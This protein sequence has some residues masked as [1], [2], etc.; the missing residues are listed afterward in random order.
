M[1]MRASSTGMN[2]LVNREHRHPWLSHFTPSCL[3]G[4]GSYGESRPSAMQVKRVIAK[5]T[6][7]EMVTGLQG[8]DEMA[9]GDGTRNLLS[10]SEAPSL[11]TWR[12]D[13]DGGIGMIP[14]S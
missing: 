5:G 11:M 7:D 3:R 9:V 13:I 2:G 12:C 6:H 14:L 10:L 4:L 1:G 8:A